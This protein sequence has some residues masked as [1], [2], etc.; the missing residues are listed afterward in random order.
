MTESSY[1]LEVL[2]VLVAAVL[3][4]SL[5]RRLRMDP[6]LGYLCAGAVIGPYSLGLVQGIATIQ[7]LAELGVV[8][9]LF[10]VGLELPIARIRVMPFR[11]FLLGIAQ[12]TITGVAISAAVAAMGVRPEAAGIIGFG[13]ALSST[14]IVLRLLADRGGLTSQTGRAAFAI[15]IVQD[16]MVGPLL[17]GVFAIGDQSSDLL[18]LLGEAAVKMIVTVALILG[19]GRILLRHIFTQVAATREPAIFAAMTLFVVLGTG[20]ATEHVGLSLA[21]GAFL[22]GMLMAETQFRHQVAAEIQPFRGLLLGLFFMT[23]GMEIHPR[24][25]IEQGATVLLLVA[26][27]LAV[28]AMILGLLAK[29]A[30]LSLA[31]AVHLG[32]LL[33]QG[34]E[35]AFILIG[36]AVTQSII[37]PALGQMVIVVVALTM[38]ATPFLAGLGQK[39]SS[40]IERNEVPS[41]EELAESDTKLQGHIIIAGFGRVGATVAKQFTEAKVPFLAIDMDP[42]TIAQAQKR[43]LPVYYGDVTRAEVLEAVNVEAARAIVIALDDKHVSLQVAAILRY[44][45]PKLKIH[46]RARDLAHAQEL[47]TI[48]ADTVVTELVPT[49]LQLAQVVLDD[50]SGQEEEKAP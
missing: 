8:F 27:L 25:I 4:V 30:R 11:V 38:L 6:V 12:V 37:E 2:I 41:I 28:K 31:D 22:A 35:F 18:T 36:A 7:A 32:V 34:G 43:G 50:D 42:H 24:L 49:G 1:L 29:L 3:A 17:V 45:F 16:L 9:L 15:L 46:A 21:F 23:V 47:E 20:V 26:G 5:F 10:T 40:R 39:A 13:V 33:A 44:I 48:G 14:A 19:I